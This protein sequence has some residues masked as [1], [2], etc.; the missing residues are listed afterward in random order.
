MKSGENHPLGKEKTQMN[1]AYQLRKIAV[2][3]TDNRFI[4]VLKQMPMTAMAQIV[5]DCVPG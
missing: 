1:V 5:G 3:I 2:S 4:S